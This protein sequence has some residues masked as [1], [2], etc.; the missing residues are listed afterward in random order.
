[1]PV[2]ALLQR[3]VPLAVVPLVGAAALLDANGVMHLVEATIAPDGPTLAASLFVGQPTVSPAGRER[4]TNADAIL[5]RNPFDSQRGPLDEPNASSPEPLADPA[6]A[7][8]CESLR[9]LAIVAMDEASKSFAEIGLTDGTSVLRRRGGE[10]AGRRVVHIGRERVWLGGD[11]SLCQ[12]VMFQSP[13]VPAASVGGPP[14]G[15]ASS[16]SA[17][18]PEAV[19]KGIVRIG[20][21]EFQVDRGVRDLLFENQ[22]LVAAY[23]R[24]TPGAGGGFRVRMTNVKPG[25]APSLLGLADGDVL[26]SIQ[27]IELTSPERALEVYARVIS[28]DRV[29]VQVL[30]GGKVV[31]VDYVVR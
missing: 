6:D 17:L 5:G 1:M 15:G 28:A 4:A 23:G 8:P 24:M 30:R 9:V 11:S 18:V 14:K 22:Q 7:P 12:L 29:S 13:S 27:G 31:N 2:S 26:Q 16:P 10:I 20:E 25:S 3:L 19:R 21:G